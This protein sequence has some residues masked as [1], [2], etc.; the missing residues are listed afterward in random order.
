MTTP[1]PL[2]LGW[3]YPVPNGGTG[4][5]GGEAMSVIDARTA[6]MPPGAAIPMLPSI[7]RGL[8]GEAVAALMGGAVLKGCDPTELLERAGIDP[9]IYGNVGMAID[10]RSY[11]RLVQQIQIALDDAFIGFF[12]EGCR[13]A[14]ETER[15]RSYL[16]CSTMGE[17]LRVSI[18]F[19]QAL[20]SDIGPRLVE[21]GNDGV[22]HVCT[23]HTIAG[24]DRDIFVW[25]RF[26]WIYHL[27]SWMIGRSLNLRRI[28]V[29]GARPVQPNGFERFALF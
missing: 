6:A 13:M 1:V 5:G 26:V 20:S 18:R 2:R 21:D 4:A 25:F 28:F 3:R 10:G 7:P 27:F 15:T 24:L 23:Y 22:M 11:F 12:H 9:A 14:L 17:A 8:D 16:H 19:T 29:R